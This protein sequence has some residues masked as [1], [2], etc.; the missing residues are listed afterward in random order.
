MAKYPEFCKPQD[1][2]TKDFSECKKQFGGLFSVLAAES[3]GGSSG[4]P[5][6]NSMT[7]AACTPTAA[8][9][10]SCA[11]IPDVE[12][13]QYHWLSRLINKDL[14]KSVFRPFGA[15]IKGADAWYESFGVTSKFV[16]SDLSSATAIEMFEAVFDM[17]FRPNK[18]N[19]IRSVS[20]A[21]WNN[22]SERETT[23]TYKFEDSYLTPSYNDWMTGKVS[24][25]TIQ[26]D[27][28]VYN[29]QVSSPT[30]VANGAFQFII[31]SRY[32]VNCQASAAPTAGSA[33][34]LIEPLWAKFKTALSGASLAGVLN[35][36]T[37]TAPFD[38]LTGA[39]TNFVAVPGDFAI[40][41]DVKYNKKNYYSPAVFTVDP[42]S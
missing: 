40:K 36:A 32:G 31:R 7:P 42:A 18:I 22:E 25:G 6:K 19:V 24:D 16:N 9:D 13:V 10:N 37:P 20:E 17:W 38:S 30:T 33:A 29:S 35:S 21:S 4:Y 34:A 28:T 11:N 3:H 12:T 2:L 23:H 26:V 15:D 1:W 27:T 8:S 41:E 39:C 5:F 14:T